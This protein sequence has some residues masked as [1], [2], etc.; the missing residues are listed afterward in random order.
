MKY[1]GM[2]LAITGLDYYLKSYTEKNRKQGEQ[3]EILG[4]K[5]ILRNCHNRDSAFR[6]LKKLYQGKDSPGTTISAMILGGVLWEFCKLQSSGKNILAKAG[7]SMILGGGISNFYDRKKKGYVVDYVS[8]GVK[9]KKLRNLVFNISDFCIF[10]GTGLYLL[11][12][13]KE[14]K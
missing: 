1:L 14:K 13:L 9:N 12:G 8:F 10:I 3:K 11:S 7:T 5:L 6:I 2:I 4:G